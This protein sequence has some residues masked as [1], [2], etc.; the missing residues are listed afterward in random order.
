MY[1]EILKKY[2]RYHIN[3]TITFDILINKWLKVPKY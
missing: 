3:I 1:K 2:I